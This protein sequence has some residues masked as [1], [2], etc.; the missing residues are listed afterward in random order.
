MNS[1]PIS[2]KGD[3][4]IN[5]C[6]LV[7]QRIK[8]DKFVKDFSTARG[9]LAMYAFAQVVMEYIVK[10]KQIQ[11]FSGLTIKV[12]PTPDMYNNPHYHSIV[13]QKLLLVDWILHY[14][15]SR[16]AF[17]CCVIR[18]YEKIRKLRKLILVV[19]CCPLGNILFL[20]VRR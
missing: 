2:T 4:A 11:D 19:G 6:E 8:E 12:P 20:R 17:K 14:A 7:S 15:K 13:G 5:F 18:N 3:D 9:P 1:S 10:K 16:K